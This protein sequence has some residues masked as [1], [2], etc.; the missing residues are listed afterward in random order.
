MGATATATGFSSSADAEANAAVQQAARELG[1]DAVPL[2]ALREMLTAAIPEDTDGFGVSLAPSKQK[3]LTLSDVQGVTAGS[4][5]YYSFLAFAEQQA[6]SHSRQVGLGFEPRSPFYAWRAWAAR[7]LPA[8]QYGTLVAL[9]QVMAD[10]AI[11]SAFLKQ[12]QHFVSSGWDV[13]DEKDS[14]FCVCDGGGG[15]GWWWWWWWWM[16]VETFTADDVIDGSAARA[17]GNQSEQTARFL[18][19]AQNLK[20][21]DHMI[22]SVKQRINRGQESVRFGKYRA[23]EDGFVE[24]VYTPVSYDDDL[25]LP[26]PP[27]GTKRVAAALED[28]QRCRKRPPTQAFDLLTS[29]LEVKYADVLLRKDAVKTMQKQLAIDT[30][31]RA[32]SGFTR[33]DQVSE[34]LEAPPAALT[35]SK[36][37]SAVE[38]D[39]IVRVLDDL[40]QEKQYQQYR[41]AVLQL[42]CDGLVTWAELQQC[43]A[44]AEAGEELQAAATEPVTWAE[45]QQETGLS[46]PG[47]QHMLAIAGNRYDVKTGLL[48]LSCDRFPSREE[49][50][51]WCLEI[52]HRL[53]QESQERYPSRDFLLNRD[54]LGMVTEPAAMAAISAL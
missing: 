19:Q 29:Y 33:A 2:P 37:L 25:F 47:L 39:G 12:A 5:A 49:N 6:L 38:R 42:Y 26:T 41:E 24:R 20:F 51:R 22:G 18:K 40:L 13:G 48:N 53:L 1:L 17:A 7:S 9:D 34:V 31:T 46:T 30:L 11:R 14:I 36:T 45:L 35:S 15:G 10:D 3:K 54:R 23:I 16:V 4:S 21:R 28:P 43:W 27:L 44:A 52:L 50:R 8:E 32:D